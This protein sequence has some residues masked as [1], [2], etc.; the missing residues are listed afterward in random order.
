MAESIHIQLANGVTTAKSAAGP[1]DKALAD[2]AL[3]GKFEHLA[4]ITSSLSTLI[5]TR[6]TAEF[7]L[8]AGFSS[9]DGD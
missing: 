8:T 6:M 4:L 5:G 3:R 9:L 1:V 2:P 7:G